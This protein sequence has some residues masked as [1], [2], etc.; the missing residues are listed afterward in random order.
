MIRPGEAS[1]SCPHPAPSGT[2]TGCRDV[3]KRTGADGL[4]RDMEDG[5][6]GHGGNVGWWRGPLQWPAVNTEHLIS[7]RKWQA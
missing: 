7:Q 6:L 2:Q 4:W 1:R 5:G 3:S